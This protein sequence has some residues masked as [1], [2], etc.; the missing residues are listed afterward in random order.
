MDPYKVLEIDPSASD[1][2]VEKA[3]RR[4][5]RKYHPDSNMRQCPSGDRRRQSLRRFSR[6]MRSL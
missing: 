1:E 2:E 5:S 4:L 6:P 3:Y